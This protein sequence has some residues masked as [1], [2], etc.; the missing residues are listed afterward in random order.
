[1]INYRGFKPKFT[2]YTCFLM[3]LALMGAPA[4]GMQKGAVE[5]LCSALAKHEKV[6][7][8]A[9]IA[10]G[11]CGLAY[12]WYTSARD[13]YNA[14]EDAYKSLL[15]A[16]W[17]DLLDVTQSAGQPGFICQAAQIYNGFP[18]E[19][20]TKELTG[21]MKDFKKAYTVAIAD[22]PALIRYQLLK[23]QYL[24]LRYAVNAILE[25]SPHGFFNHAIGGD[26]PGFIS[27]H[28]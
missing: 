10:T 27:P 14:Q 19:Y 22:E 5:G 13:T 12:A 9:A 15:G 3:V 26:A 6:I 8:T 21:I 18:S 1:M 7:A 4:L 20:K 2:R 24:R 23:I 16:A 28:C 11:V 25:K 17:G